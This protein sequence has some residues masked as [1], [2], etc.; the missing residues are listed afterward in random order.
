MSRNYEDTNH[1][2]GGVILEGTTGDHFCVKIVNV[3]RKEVPYK[4]P[5]EVELKE[6]VKGLHKC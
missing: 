4:S 6:V 1:Q 3:E 5:S 2:T